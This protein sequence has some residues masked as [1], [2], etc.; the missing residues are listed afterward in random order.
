MAHIPV[1]NYEIDDIQ[2]GNKYH[3]SI[4]LNTDSR[5]ILL[6]IISE[7]EF[8]NALMILRNKNV[9]Y[10]SETTQLTVTL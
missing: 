5:P 9:I 8:N 1:I 7:A 2:I 6:P 10:D 4:W 3:R